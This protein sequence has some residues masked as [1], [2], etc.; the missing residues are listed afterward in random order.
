MRRQHIRAMA[1][2]TESGMSQFAL[3]DRVRWLLSNN[4]VPP[5][6]VGTV[7]GFQTTGVLV[8]FPCSP[9]LIRKLASTEEGALDLCTRISI[10][11]PQV[12]WKQGLVTQVYCRLERKTD[13]FFYKVLFDSGE[14]MDIDLR[15]FESKLVLTRDEAT[16]CFLDGDLEKVD[17]ES[18]LYKFH[19]WRHQFCT[20]LYFVRNDYFEV[21][22]T[23][24]FVTCMACFLVLL[25]FL[26]TAG[27]PLTQ[28]SS[29]SFL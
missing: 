21:G 7:V 5:R 28:V 9:M 23:R 15:N 2:E 13:V 26:L 1:K 6:S 3:G 8:E 16:L 11:V 29:T 20:E 19:D 10:L 27:L 24:L 4:R 17:E 12:G 14:D 18:V 25:T 22:M